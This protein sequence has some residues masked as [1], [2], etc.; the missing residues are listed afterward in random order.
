MPAT[1]RLLALSTVAALACVLSACKEKPAEP[2]KPASTASVPAPA[3]APTRE[4]AMANLMALPEIKALSAQI[5]KSSGGKA[6]GAVIEDDPEPRIINGKPYWQFSFVENRPDAVHR[7][8]SFL[9]AKSGEE[10]L[11]EDVNNDTMLTLPE[12]RRIV[13]KVELRSKD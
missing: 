4:Q 9:V 7:R 1:A 12:W 10:I 11:V 3:P 6:H 2:P 5:E 13:R 8:E